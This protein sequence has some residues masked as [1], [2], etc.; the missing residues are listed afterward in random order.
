MTNLYTRRS[1]YGI[2]NYIIATI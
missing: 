1:K 2:Q